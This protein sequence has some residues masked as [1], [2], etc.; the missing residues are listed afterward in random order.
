MWVEC[1][2]TEGATETEVS[3]RRGGCLG[4]GGAHVPMLKELTEAIALFLTNGPSTGSAVQAKEQPRRCLW[5]LDLQRL[6]DVSP[7]DRDVAPVRKRQH[8]RPDRTFS[9]LRV[10]CQPRGR[11]RLVGGAILTRGG[12]LEAFCITNTA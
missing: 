3:Q 10:L 9:S 5:L 7:R 11:L 8:S 2:A 12:L 1:V 6:S 4:T